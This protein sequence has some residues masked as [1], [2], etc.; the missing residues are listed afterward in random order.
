MQSEQYPQLP[1]KN[2]DIKRFEPVNLV[3]FTSPDDEGGLKLGQAL[4]S[5][6]RQL[7]VIVGVTFI[8]TSLALLKAITSKPTYQASFEI[9]AK[10]ITEE[11]RVISQV[12]LNN[13]DDNSKS[14]VDSTTL[15]LL[16]SP[17]I[18]NPIVD[19]LKLKYPDV[20]YESL[21]DGLVLKV[22]TE[23]E[24]LN[25]SYEDKDSTKVKAVLDLVSNA[26]LD[27]SLE[28]RLAEVQQGLDFVDSQL[29][30]IEESAS[31][32]QDKLQSFR[33]QYNL[34][35]PEST[36][37]QLAEQISTISQQR[38]ENQ[39]KL[40]EAYA[41]AFDLD[42]QLANPSSNS[43]GSAALQDNA[44]YQSL[45]SQIQVLEI[46]IAKDLSVFQESTDKIKVLRD[47][48]TNLLALLSQEGERTKELLASQIRELESRSEIL[49]QAEEQLNQQVKQLS[50][51][52]RQYN[53][54]Q[55]EIKIT[56]D[57]LNQ[58]LTKREALRIDA[59]QRKT[60]WQI[61]T[62]LKDPV[63]SSSDIKRNAL[64][65][66]ILG[67]LLG[68]GIALLRDKLSNLLRTPNE[69]K[70]TSKL[71]IL[72]VIPFN[73]ALISDKKQDG[74]S[75]LIPLEKSLID[76]E[77]NTTIEKLIEIIN[78]KSLVQRSH[79][80]L[81][82]EANATQP[83]YMT[84]I[85]LE[86]FRSLYTNIRLLSPDD[87]IRSIVI[88]SSLPSEGK[89]TTSVYLAQAAAALGKR[90]LLVD[91]DLRRPKLHE[92]LH[93]SNAVG[94]SNLISS[95]L[96]FDEV[97]QRSPIEPNLSILTSGHLPPDPT[98]LISSQK[99]QDLMQLFQETFDLV[100]Y[101]TPPLIGM[102]DAKL[103][104]SKTD[105]IIMVVGL[106]KTKVSSLNQALEL[107]SN[108]PIVVFGIVAN[109]SKDYVA[110]LNDTYKHY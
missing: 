25:V 79:K 43:K 31:K 1:P 78:I 69:V 5:L 24:I 61:L 12:T 100:I 54:I 62:P 66:V 72:G 11:T 49:S 81:E 57:N 35:D 21:S 92:R 103:L 41:L 85:F 102:V 28:E 46:Q 55:Q 33:Q 97:V 48:Q 58:F 76:N 4:Q 17:R 42:S 22:I 74:I 95:N 45:L 89:S 70:D 23:A 15:K 53:D 2:S 67:L 8:V 56:N 77:N 52:S 68:I 80:R 94:L 9:L 105:G 51:V 86:S 110:S 50:I 37:K 93:F 13:R 82:G 109:R 19:Q 108:S 10:V 6:H 32:L 104:A 30:K 27:Y 64:L 107:L 7:P 73:S 3:K 84:S 18:I 90:V 20:N 59:G 71:P 14:S 29:P 96:S 26:Y 65:G 16:K 63:A 99:M 101:D 36:R 38:L 91:A 87:K 88:S 60:P 83:Y 75:D 106:D 98:R 44:R 39:V 34:I 40:D 47:Q